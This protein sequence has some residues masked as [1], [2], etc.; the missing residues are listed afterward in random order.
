MRRRARA[1]RRPLRCRFCSAWQS[2]PCVLASLGPFALILTPTR[3]LAQQIQDNFVAYGK[4]LAIFSCVLF[5]G[6]NQTAQVNAL[7]RGADIVVACP[8]RLLDLMGQGYI[9]LDY[10]ETFVLDEADRMLDMGFIHDVR[11]IAAKLPEKHQTL[12]FSATMPAE[13]EDLAMQ[14]LH[15]PETVK[16][17]PVSSPV[18]AIDQVLYYVDKA[19]KKHLLAQLF[20]RSRTWRMRWSSRARVTVRIALCAIWRRLAFLRRRFTAT[21]V[22]T[23]VRRRWT[24]SSAAKARSWLPQTLRPAALTLR[25]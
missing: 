6:V 20:R 16:V 4:Q 23:P 22:K 2:D 5:G 24:A 17:D 7:H 10:V 12:L 15:H 18:E 9:R 8:G 25:D 19:N 3:E 1:R 11:K 21:R 14:L 13:V